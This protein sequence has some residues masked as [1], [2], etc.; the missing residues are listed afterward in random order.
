VDEAIEII[1]QSGIK[2]ETGAF[3]TVVEGTYA[4][5]MAVVHQINEHLL[6]R[7]CTNGLQTFNYRYAAPVISLVMKKPANFCTL[8]DII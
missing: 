8:C 7:G 5:V 6:Q 1:R 3:A 2:N 4:E